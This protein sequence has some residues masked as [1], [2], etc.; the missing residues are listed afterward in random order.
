MIAAGAESFLRNSVPLQAGH[1]G[2]TEELRTSSS[3]SFPQEAHSY[4]YMGMACLLRR[5]DLKF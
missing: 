3:N 2:A 1:S 4:S 5:N